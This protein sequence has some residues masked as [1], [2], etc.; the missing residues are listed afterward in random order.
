[1][2]PTAPLPEE[3]GSLLERFHAGKRTALARAISV[4]ENE[5]PGFQE[6][7][8]LVLATGPRARRVGLTG[9]PGGGKSSLIATLANLYRARNEEVGVVAVDPTSP[10][11]GGAL[12]GD[13]IRMNDLATD[14]GIFVRSMATRGSLGGLAATSKEVIDLMDAFGLSRL[15]I[16]T[17]GVGQTELEIT[18]AV[19]T[20]VVV[21]VP[22]SGDGI[23]AM[24]A[25]LMEIADIFVVNKADRPGVDHVLNDLRAALHLREGKTGGAAPAHHGVDLGRVKKKG[26]TAAP[27]PTPAGD[28]HWA[29]PVLKTVAQTGEGVPELLDAIDQHREQLEGS[30]ELEVRRRGRAAVRVREVT[31]RALRGVLWGADSTDALLEAGLDGIQQRTATPYSVSA[32]ILKG[33]LAGD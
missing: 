20:V 18:G 30:G 26:E 21:L 29:I 28:A 11:S 14:R 33:F 32:S 9:P 24:K 10:Y 4:I 15:L 7:L 23:Q 31:E 17:V 3:L 2:D 8:H 22:E 5:R 27:Q 1:M 19:D 16:E 6:F 13:R 25:G 12:L